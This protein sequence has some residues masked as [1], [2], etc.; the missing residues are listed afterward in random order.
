MD[1]AEGH[2][3]GEQ[4]TQSV[5]VCETKGLERKFRIHISC[6]NIFIYDL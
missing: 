1:K 6:V 3:G 5:E 2:G 4:E